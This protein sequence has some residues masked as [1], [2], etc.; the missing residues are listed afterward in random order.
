V[1]FNQLFEEMLIL[2]EEGVMLS[3]ASGPVVGGYCP[4]AGPQLLDC[5]C[6]GAAAVGGGGS[7]RLAIRQL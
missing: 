6:G 4:I 3:R 7:G 1:L 2:I 5:V